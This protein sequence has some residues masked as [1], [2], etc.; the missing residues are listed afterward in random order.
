[1]TPSGQIESHRVTIDDK[2][3]AIV[4]LVKVVTLVRAALV[5]ELRRLLHDKNPGRSLSS[6]VIVDSKCTRR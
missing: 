1:M 3:N 2:T 4:I 6:V 5:T